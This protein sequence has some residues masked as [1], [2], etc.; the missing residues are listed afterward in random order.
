MNTMIALD[1]IPRRMAELGYANAYYTRFR[2]LVLRPSEVME[3]SAGSELYILI[4]EVADISVSSDFGVYDL[5]FA[6]T[7]E[8]LYEH[9][10]SIRIENH[11]KG[12]NHIRFIQVIPINK[13]P[14]E[15]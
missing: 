4:E 5:S 14:L 2:H 13:Y 6:F 11:G 1:Y 15:N 9:Q 12:L 8:Q 10:G 3:I 7:N